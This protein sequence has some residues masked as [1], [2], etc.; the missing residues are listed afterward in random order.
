MPLRLLARAAPI[1]LGAI[2]AAMWLRS[3][4]PAR[5]ELPVRTGPGAPP[6]AGA[7]AAA[8]VDRSAGRFERAPVDIVTVVDDLLGA[9][10]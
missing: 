2:A 1:V 5:P 8:P 7:A 3:R 6:V 4:R 10:R 9:P